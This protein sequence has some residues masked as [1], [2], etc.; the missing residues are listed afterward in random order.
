MGI[1]QQKYERKC[2][3]VDVVLVCAFSAPRISSTII[4]ILTPPTSAAVQRAVTQKFVTNPTDLILSCG[5]RRSWEQKPG[6]WLTWWFVSFFNKSPSSEETGHVTTFLFSPPQPHEPAPLV[7]E[8]LS[9]PVAT[10]TL[11]W[12]G[13]IRDMLDGLPFAVVLGDEN[14][15]FGQQS[16][17]SQLYHKL[18]NLSIAFQHQKMYTAGSSQPE[19]KIFRSG[20]STSAVLFL[21]TGI[22]LWVTRSCCDEWWGSSLHCKYFYLHL[23]MYAIQIESLGTLVLPHIHTHLNMCAFPQMPEMR[24]RRR[25]RLEHDFWIC[26]SCL[27]SEDN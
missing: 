6:S 16:P 1:Y 26:N 8:L 14:K 13:K 24:R 25:R 22:M 5:A 19:L 20:L 12:M 21:V 7:I 3:S 4:L 27:S 23:A 17:A 18:P 9:W 15:D 2:W 11:V 10:T